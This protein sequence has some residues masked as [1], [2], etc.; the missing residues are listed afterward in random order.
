MTKEDE[1]IILKIEEIIDIILTNQNNYSVTIDKMRLLNE[2]FKDNSDLFSEEFIRSYIN[3]LEIFNPFFEF[4]LSKLEECERDLL[5]S[6]EIDSDYFFSFSFHDFK[7]KN[8]LKDYRDMIEELDNM[9]GNNNILKGIVLFMHLKILLNRY[10]FT[11]NK[12][13]ISNN[14]PCIDID[15]ASR[16]VN[17]KEEYITIFREELEEGIRNSVF[18]DDEEIKNY[19]IS[20][21]KELNNE[22]C[23]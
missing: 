6:N 5:N 14:N 11:N 10:N 1:K 23:N 7:T 20:A 13:K 22:L 8:I 15:Y 18:V 2:Y 16:L 4:L 12:I 21:I 9:F 19:I 3:F 17:L